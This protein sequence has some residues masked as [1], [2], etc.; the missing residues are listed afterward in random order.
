MKIFNKKDVFTIV[1]EEEAKAYIG[2]QGY[3]GNSLEDLEEEINKYGSDELEEVVHEKYTSNIFRPRGYEST[4]SLFL[5]DDKV[6]RL[7]EPTKWR[8]FKDHNEFKAWVGKDVG[9]TIR[10]REI[11]SKYD[12]EDLITGLN[13]KTI[14]LASTCYNYDE[15]FNQYEW[16]NPRNEWQPF[17]VGE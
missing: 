7:K 16:L 3:F 6:K 11:S 2:K 10:T 5:P 9:E 17:G 4:Y 8:P 1:T 15:L 12:S 13:Y 14:C